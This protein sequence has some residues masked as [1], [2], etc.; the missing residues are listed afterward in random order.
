MGF[1]AREPARSGG[2]VDAGNFRQPGAS[3]SRR[4]DRGRAREVVRV[5]QEKATFGPAGIGL[6]LEFESSPLARHRI[7][8]WVRWGLANGSEPLQRS[9]L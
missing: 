6:W 8:D 1:D 4:Q 7:V 2:E 3:A 9:H 5:G